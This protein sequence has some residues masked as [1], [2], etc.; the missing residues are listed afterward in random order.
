MIRTDEEFLKKLNGIVSKNTSPLI[1][2]VRFNLGDLIINQDTTG[3][4]VYIILE[5]IVKCHV[6][7][8]NGKEFIQEFFG[9][10]KL[11]GEIEALTKTKSFSNVTALSSVC[12]YK[13]DN[14]H[15]LD[16]IGK[17][18]ELALAI[19]RSTAL[20]LR[21]TAVRASFQQT[22]K[23]RESLQKLARSQ[24]SYQVALT[25]KDIASYLGVTMRSLNRDIKNLGITILLPDK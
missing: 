12:L 20:K 23:V 4:Y 6:N 13:I 14:Y 25:K 17:Q 21:Q 9:P 8:P 1:K 11:L 19:L 3:K 22:H 7:E 2:K 24:P 10:G 15:F 18:D 5:G 16:L